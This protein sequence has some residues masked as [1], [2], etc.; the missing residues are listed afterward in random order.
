MTANSHIA[1]VDIETTGLTPDD[2]VWE[3]ACI[4]RDP[5]GESTTHIHIDHHIEFARE[6]PEK[7]RA[8]HDARFGVGMH[9]YSQ[10]TAAAIIHA[11]LADAHIVGAN[12]AFDVA[13]LTRLLSYASLKPSWHY[14]LIDLES[15]TLGYLMNQGTQPQ[16]PWRS[17]DLAASVGAPTVDSDGDYLYD[18]HTGM[19]D[20]EWC[21]DWWDVLVGL[22]AKSVA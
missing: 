8:D 14:H 15:V 9:V 11:A 16:I 6:L 4:R 20:A 18:R 7:F 5:D 22:R 21:R 17:D 19:G 13:M 2:E 10:H 3:F 12:P 1:F